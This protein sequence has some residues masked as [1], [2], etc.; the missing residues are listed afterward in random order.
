MYVV[1]VSLIRGLAVE[2][3]LTLFMNNNLEGL[4][5]QNGVPREGYCFLTGESPVMVKAGAM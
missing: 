1:I 3:L 4:N 2:K 5:F